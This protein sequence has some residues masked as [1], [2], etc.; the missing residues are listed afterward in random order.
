MIST[1]DGISFWRTF[2][3]CDTAQEVRIQAVGHQEFCM[4]GSYSA[5]NLEKSRNLKWKIA[6]VERSWISWILEKSWQFKIKAPA[7]PPP[8]PPKK[9]EEEK[10]TQMLCV[11]FNKWIFCWMVACQ[12]G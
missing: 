4:Q 3:L 10:E 7:P 11:C 8:P 12:R 6:G 5:E 9:K 1:V 2:A